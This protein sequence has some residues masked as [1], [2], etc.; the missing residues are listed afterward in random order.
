MKTSNKNIMKIFSAL[1][2]LL[3][4]LPL[5]FSCNTAGNLKNPDITNSAKENETAAENTVSSTEAAEPNIP[6]TD[7]NGKE[8]NILVM[9]YAGYAPLNI[10][11]IDVPELNGEVLNDAAYNRNL[12][13]EQ[14]YNCKINTIVYAN[15]YS[16]LNKMV[17][18][19]KAGDPTY[20]LCVVRAIDYL[21][22]LTQGLL[23]NLNETPNINTDNPWWDKKTADAMSLGK[24]NYGLLGD[25]STSVMNCIWNT[26][27]NKQLLEDFGLEDPYALVKD[28]KWTI[29]KMYEMSKGVAADVNGDGKRDTEDRYG[30][31]H[32]VDSP[33][34]LLNSF[35]ERFADIDANGMPYF[36]F[37][38]DSAFTKF[39]HITE[40]FKDHDTCFN[41]HF[42]TN[43][44]SKYEAQ[45]FI[46]NQ[47]LFCLGGIY[48]GPEM[49]TMDSEYGILPYPKYDET[50]KEYYNATVVVALP[51]ITIPQ[52]NTNL[53]NTG[54]FLE[55]YAYQGYKNIRPAFYDI[56]LQRKIAR[57]N[58]SADM[59]NFIFN[60]IFIDI[61]AMY[62]FGGISTA[63]NQMGGKGDTNIASYVEK[64][65]DKIN[66]DIQKFIDVMTK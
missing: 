62:N 47:A 61:G 7:M 43:D 51:F 31:A 58:E 27:F 66:A 63:I 40:I 46:H 52:T 64:N 39:I 35:G 12:Y 36:S 10:M 45:M 55:A 2:A 19:I 65:Q 21:S 5:I 18:P 23:V 3:L 11:D 38:T 44:A 59:L 30:I 28:G 29:D 48:Y 16:D 4:A 25:Y 8:F 49:R 9:N 32:I 37:T 34:S 17:K 1:L 13:M 60:N 54:L 41:A 6:V 24:K 26:Y 42:R 50:Q 53:E 56:V 22:V 20:D 57:D 33:T 15:N 14:T